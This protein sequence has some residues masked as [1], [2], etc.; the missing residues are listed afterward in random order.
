MSGAGTNYDSAG[1]AIRK[2]LDGKVNLRL[3]ELARL[4][5]RFYHV[6]SFIVNANHSIM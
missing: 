1:S 2:L 5:M 6:A 4:L 3:F